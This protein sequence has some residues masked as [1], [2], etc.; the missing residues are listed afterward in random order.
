MKSEIK[1]ELNNND[2]L[3]DF[4]KKSYKGGKIQGSENSLVVKKS[5]DKELF[6]TL[7]DSDKIIVRITNKDLID[8]FCRFIIEKNSRGI[9]LYPM[10][11]HYIVDHNKWIFF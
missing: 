11:I 9:K 2:L 10:S 4:F 6:N 7:K 8:G 5:D 3:L 1:A